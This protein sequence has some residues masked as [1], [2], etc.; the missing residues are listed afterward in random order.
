MLI[1]GLSQAEYARQYRKDN[2][3]TILRNRLQHAAN[4]LR[5]HGYIITA[6]ETGE[7]VEEDG[8]E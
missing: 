4:L 7:S 6:P 3:E 8:E 5:R 1:K 2:P